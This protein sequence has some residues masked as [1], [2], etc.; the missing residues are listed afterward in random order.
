[1]TDGSPDGV[2]G[3]KMA[4]ELGEKGALVTSMEHNHPRAYPP[5]GYARGSNIWNARWNE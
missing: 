4:T 1:V 5:S 3:N 2:G